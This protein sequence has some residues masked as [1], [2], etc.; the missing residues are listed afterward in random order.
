MFIHIFIK[1]SPI[2]YSDTNPTIMRSKILGLESLPNALM[3][4]IKDSDSSWYR[5]IRPLKISG[6]ENSINKKPFLLS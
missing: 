4:T 6:H 5:R 3:H 1:N 2:R